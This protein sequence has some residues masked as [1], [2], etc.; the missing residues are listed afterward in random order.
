MSYVMYLVH[1]F[2]L[3]TSTNPSWNRLVKH[4]KRRN[5]DHWSVGHVIPW[6]EEDGTWITDPWSVHHESSVFDWKAA[7][8]QKSVLIFWQLL[9]GNMGT[10]G[11]ALEVRIPKMPKLTGESGRMTTKWLWPVALLFS[12]GGAWRSEELGIIVSATSELCGVVHVAGKWWEWPVL[13]EAVGY[14]EKRE[15]EEDVAKLATLQQQRGSESD[16]K[17]DRE[18]DNVI[19]PL[20]VM[21]T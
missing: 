14:G 9:S 2:K 12:K 4:A 8:V 13:M 10:L 17:R 11:K 1:D 19:W 6:I 5:V 3:G 18:K 16:L 15:K 21:T 20:M 7:V